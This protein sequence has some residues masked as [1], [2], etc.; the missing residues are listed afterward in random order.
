MLINPVTLVIQ[1][2]FHKHA[3]FANTLA[4]IFQD[5]GEKT[6]IFKNSG[7]VVGMTF[8]YCNNPGTD[9]QIEQIG[10]RQDKRGVAQRNLDN[11]LATH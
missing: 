4:D 6:V 7:M 11:A 5:L 8:S 2:K 1:S 9:L 3:W 10:F